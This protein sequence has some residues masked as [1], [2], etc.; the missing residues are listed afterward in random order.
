MTPY[1]DIRLNWM[2]EQISE[3]YIL[4]SASACYEITKAFIEIWTTELYMTKIIKEANCY[5]KWLIWIFW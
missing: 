1:T 2:R 4:V 3:W 5:D